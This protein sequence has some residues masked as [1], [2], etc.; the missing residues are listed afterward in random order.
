[1]LNLTTE[2]VTVGLVVS[3]IITGAAFFVKR[4]RAAVKKNFKLVVRIGEKVF[5]VAWFNSKRSK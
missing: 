3:A 1:M 4:F 2:P 5:M